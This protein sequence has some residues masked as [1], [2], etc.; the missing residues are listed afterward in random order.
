MI[1]LISLFKNEVA[2]ETQLKPPSTSFYK[3]GEKALGSLPKPWFTLDLMPNSH[4]DLEERGLNLPIQNAQAGHEDLL[5]ENSATDFWVED[6]L[7]LLI[8]FIKGQRLLAVSI[9]GS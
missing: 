3:R 5:S 9:L 4:P 2:L 1:K 7:E 6:T 8:R